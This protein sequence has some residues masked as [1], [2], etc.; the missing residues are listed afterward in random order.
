VASGAFVG[1]GLAGSAAAMVLWAGAMAL[2]AVGAGVSHTGKT[3]VMAMAAGVLLIVAASAHSFTGLVS[4]I[5]SAGAVFAI[6][7]LVMIAIQG[8]RKA[9]T[10]RTA[11]R[12]AYRHAKWIEAQARAQASQARAQGRRARRWERPEAPPGD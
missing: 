10:S 6:A 12:A 11:M 5:L 4:A 3:I 1:F 2:T 9:R 7:S 8:G